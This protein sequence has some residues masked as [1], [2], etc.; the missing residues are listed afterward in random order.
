MSRRPGNATAVPAVHDGV[1]VVST[2]RHELRP[3]DV[4]AEVLHRGIR[5]AEDGSRPKREEHMRI[6]ILSDI[7][8]NAEALRAV[9]RDVAREQ[10]SEL[11]CLGDLVGYNAQAA[12]V[13]ALARR[14]GIASVYGHHDL[15]VAG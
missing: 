15:M 1:R 5:H 8:G 10:S 2:S 12:D 14:F 13:I 11:V 6:A 3:R 9:L 4:R 7:H